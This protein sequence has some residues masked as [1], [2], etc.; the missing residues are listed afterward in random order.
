MSTDLLEQPDDQRPSNAHSG[1]ES[2]RRP[3][4]PQSAAVGCGWTVISGD[5]QSH[6]DLPCSRTI[7]AVV[8]PPPAH[9]LSF[10][11]GCRQTGQA[12]ITSVSIHIASKEQFT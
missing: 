6:P 11:E 2:R 12:S 1:A 3:V 9:H 4:I 10:P 7:V 5:G 8:P